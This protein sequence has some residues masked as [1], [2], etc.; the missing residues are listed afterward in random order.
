MTSYPNA[1]SR[2]CT[3]H[4]DT[5][6]AASPTTLKRYL[7]GCSRVCWGLVVLALTHGH[8]GGKMELGFRGRWF[9][10]RPLVVFPPTFIT[11]YEKI[12]SNLSRKVF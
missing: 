7:D 2:F 6:R 12:N 10:C 4:G 5:E 11:Y 1:I 8:R 9:F 3:Q